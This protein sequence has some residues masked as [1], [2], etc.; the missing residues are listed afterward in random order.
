MSDVSVGSDTSVESGTS[1][2]EREEDTDDQEDYR[3]Y[4]ANTSATPARQCV[5]GTTDQELAEH[6]AAREQIEHR[7]AITPRISAHEVQELTSTTGEPSPKFRISFSERAA[8][9]GHFFSPASIWWWKRKE[10]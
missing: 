2:D 6:P 7:H 10:S 9:K 1:I 5:A 3:E 4:L 8:Q